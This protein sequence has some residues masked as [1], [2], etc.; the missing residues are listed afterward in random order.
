MANPR[1]TAMLVWALGV[2][3]LRVFVRPAGALS[4]ER[5]GRDLIF[6]ILTEP[7][8]RSAF[9]EPALQI[10]EAFVRSAYAR[11]DVCMAA[12]ESDRVLGYAW[13]STGRSPH[14]SGLWIEPHA[15]SGYAYDVFVRPECRGQ[16]IAPWLYI[17]LD[18]FL[19]QQGRRAMLS[20]IDWDNEASI[21]AALR[22]GA[23]EAGYVALLRLFGRHFVYCSQGTRSSGLRFTKAR[24]A[25]PQ[26]AFPGNSSAPRAFQR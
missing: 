4:R 7:E 10:P 20:G 26:A 16:R 14:A 24:R 18:R 22:A 12:L 15:A 2:R 21:K 8:A 25:R 3:L 23:R 17:A 13:L 5:C 6:R 19:V 11:G 1:L 9:S